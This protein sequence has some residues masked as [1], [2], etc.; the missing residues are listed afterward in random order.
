MDPSVSV[1]RLVDRAEMQ[2]RDVSVVVGLCCVCGARWIRT[3]DLLLIRYPGLNAVL[4]RENAGR[5]RA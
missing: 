5:G 4:A 3:I 2:M 1:A